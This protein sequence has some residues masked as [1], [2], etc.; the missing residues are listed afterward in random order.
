MIRFK[1][2][3]VVRVTVLRGKYSHC[4]NI[5]DVGVV[6]Q[7]DPT[8]SNLGVFF[9]VR[10]AGQWLHPDEVELVTTKWGVANE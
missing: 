3:D 6:L 10:G 8:E 9:K 7:I 2:G 1:V 5:G 4:F